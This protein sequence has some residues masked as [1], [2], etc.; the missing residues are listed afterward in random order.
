VTGATT[1]L[2]I[3]RHGQAEI[4]VKRSRFLCDLRRVDSEDAAREVLAAIRKQ[5]WG[6]GHHCSAMIIGADAAIERSNDD[7]EPSG[8][9][10]APMLEVLRGH[11]VSNVL[12]VVSRWF[13]GTLLGSGGLARAYGDG[14]RAALEDLPL[15]RRSL[16]EEFTVA[17]DHNRAGRVEN[18]LRSRGVQV[19]S[20]EYAERALIRVG[21]AAGHRDQLE[22]TLAEVMSEQVDLIPVGS[23]W[24]D[25]AR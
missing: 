21:A 19:L 3:A 13:G 14:V 17:V 24:V 10:G 16:V 9:A 1:Y 22:S 7:G 4:E 6:A 23:S 5:H 18:D 20:T 2:T 25:S 8:T 15:V 11:G 12:A